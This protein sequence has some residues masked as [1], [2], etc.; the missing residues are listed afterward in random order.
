MWR[1]NIML[2]NNQRIKG[3]KKNLKINEKSNKTYQNILDIAKAVLKEKFIA[4]QAYL[5][6]QC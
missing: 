6:K 3:I 4:I 2:L 5:G 1:L